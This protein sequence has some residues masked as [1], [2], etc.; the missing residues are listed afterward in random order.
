M[1]NGLQD[2]II[3]WVILHHNGGV[4]RTVLDVLDEIIGQMA[5]REGVGWPAVIQAKRD[6]GMW[7]I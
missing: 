7:R 2:K 6:L 3:E 1:S 4:S 5:R